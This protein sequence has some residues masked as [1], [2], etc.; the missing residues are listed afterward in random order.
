[1]GATVDGF[2]WL[3]GELGQPC[4]DVC[5]GMPLDAVA[6]LVHG[7]SRAVV[8][9]VSRRYGLHDYLTTTSIDTTC[10]HV[11]K[12]SSN[13]D[14]GPAAFVFFPQSSAWD[15]LP[16]ESAE[17][18]APVYRASCACTT[19]PPPP[20]PPPA[21]LPPPPSP[22]H[23]PP[24][25][26]APVVCFHAIGCVPLSLL[27]FVVLALFLACA[28]C[29]GWL[30]WCDHRRPR[31]LQAFTRTGD[32]S[33][34]SA[35]RSW[36]SINPSLLP[37][38]SWCRVCCCWCWPHIARCWRTFREVSG[39]PSLSLSHHHHTH[40]LSLSRPPPSHTLAHVRVPRARRPP[41]TAGRPPRAAR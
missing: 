24:F 12:V 25:P 27:V 34:A 14:L 28:A 11:S 39:T 10:R 20:A 17:A 19:L 31:K 35:N 2:C 3:L 22:P 8:D 40:S 26:P 36:A 38:G 5:E 13:E 18:L 1:V 32:G 23:P 9:A 4:T 21:P 37:W 6:T 33:W 16:G 15:C 41:H 29:C 7:S 30:C